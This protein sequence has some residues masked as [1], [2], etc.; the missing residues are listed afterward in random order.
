MRDS[1]CSWG[2]LG[3]QRLQGDLSS[4][5]K[6]SLRPCGAVK[7]AEPGDPC[8]YPPTGKLRLAP[9]KPVAFCAREGLSVGRSPTD[10]SLTHMS[11]T[12]VL[13]Q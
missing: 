10:R 6:S 9:K 7:W 3:R 12:R 5:V 1:P 2:S 8:P 4:Y 11:G 13:A